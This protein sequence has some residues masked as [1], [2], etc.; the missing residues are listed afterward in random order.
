MEVLSLSGDG[1]RLV[2][3]VGAG[4][5]VLILTVGAQHDNGLNKGFCYLDHSYLGI[6]ISMHPAS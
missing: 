4:N 6:D 3:A 1:L 2:G 5:Y